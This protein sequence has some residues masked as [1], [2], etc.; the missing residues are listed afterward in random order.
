[1]TRANLARMNE[2]PDT[3]EMTRAILAKA[4]RSRVFFVEKLLGV[5]LERWQRDVL[6]ALDRGDTRISIRSGHGVG[7]TALCSWVALH[8]LLFRNSVKIVVTSP[9]GK[10]MTDGLKPELSLWIERLPEGLGLK[11]N[12]EVLND[13]IVKHPDFKNN[14]ISF[15]T[16]RLE[17]PEALAGI[18]AD[19]VLVIVDEASGVPEVVYEAAAGTLSTAGSICILIGNPTRAR[20]LFYRTHTALRGHWVTFKVSS[21]DSDRVDQAFI[22]DI[23]KTYGVDSNQYRVR[24]QGEFPTT[25]EDQVIPLELVQSAIGRDVDEIPGTG[26][27]WGVDPGRGGDSTGFVV[28]SANW[29]REMEEWNFPDLMRLVGKV[30]VK[31]DQTL[32]ENRPEAIYVDSIGLG[33]GVADRLR[34]MG[35]PVIDVNVAE[36]PAMRE[37]YPRLRAELWFQSRE[38]FETRNVRLPPDHALTEQLMEELTAPEMRLLSNGK[39]DVESKEDMKKRGLKS[40]NLADALNLTFAFQGSIQAGRSTPMSPWNKPIRSRVVGVF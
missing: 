38:W 23:R 35:L 6:A 34:E 9:S 18:H 8:Y 16:A 22:Q 32:T 40:P 13:R 25:E 20:G 39:T 27:Y 19:H 29:L 24:V 12:L 36:A 37:R 30:K 14:F 33:A 5:K 15:R 10:Q 11:E 7:K 21:E 2:R 17:T 1:M 28:R 3:H 31:W 26:V 4:A